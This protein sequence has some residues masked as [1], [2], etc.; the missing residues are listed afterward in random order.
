MGAYFG[1][2]TEFKWHFVY[3]ILLLFTERKAK[4][5]AIAKWRFLVGG[6]DPMLTAELGVGRV[7]TC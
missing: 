2:S 5:L 4:V 7:S 6:S 3:G 1:P